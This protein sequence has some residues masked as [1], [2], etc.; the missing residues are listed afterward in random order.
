MSEAETLTVTIRFGDVTAEFKG[1]PETVVN[2]IQMFIAKHIPQLDLARKISISY[3]L[4]EVIQMFQDRIKITP[5][6]PRIWPAGSD[7]SDKE[8]VGLQLV[9][10]KIGHESGRLP[11]A[12]LSPAEIQ[13]ST[14]L[15][16]KSI[17]SR[18]SELSK[19]GHVMKETTD[20]GVGYRITTQGIAWLHQVLSKRQAS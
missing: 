18:L 10:A 6:G 13:S 12:L 8:I 11:S 9:A 17:S 15:N 2:S 7:L 3:S 20:K 14:G 19:T 1:S 5:E 4:A 16:A